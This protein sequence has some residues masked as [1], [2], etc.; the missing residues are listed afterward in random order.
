MARSSK[1]I[2]LRDQLNAIREEKERQLEEVKAEEQNLTRQKA[3][4]VIS[5]DEYLKKLAELGEKRNQIEQEAV[6]KQKSI[7]V[8]TSKQEQRRLARISKKLAKEEKKDKKRVD[9]RDKKLVE[10]KDHAERVAL[11]NAR[12]DDIDDQRKKQVEY[13][14]KQS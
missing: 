7:E 6:V 11:A 1:N 14:K 2:E 5:E 10:G 8:E 9:V 4:K 13:Q 3:D 12:R